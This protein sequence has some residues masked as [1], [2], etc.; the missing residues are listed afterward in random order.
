MAVYLILRVIK[1]LVILAFLAVA[2]QYWL[3]NKSYLFS[4]EEI[5]KIAE[6][7]AGEWRN[8]FAKKFIQLSHVAKVAVY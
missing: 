5:A 1:W 7:Y 6:K 2:I 3:L 8:T 4:A